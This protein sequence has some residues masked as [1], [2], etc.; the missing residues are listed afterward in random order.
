MVERFL[1]EMMSE[2]GNLFDFLVRRR[3]L[4]ASIEMD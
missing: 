2:M 3:V 1:E 4:L